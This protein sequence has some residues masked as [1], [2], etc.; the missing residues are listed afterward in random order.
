VS[1]EA[2]SDADLLPLLVKETVGKIS[3]LK[4][5]ETKP[6]SRVV[7]LLVG[8]SPQGGGVFDPSKRPLVFDSVIL[9]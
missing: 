3:V 6:G 9:G 5:G 7:I 8:N 2:G 4:S 1:I